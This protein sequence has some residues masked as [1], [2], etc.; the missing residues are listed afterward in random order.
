MQ[1]PY[2]G[3]LDAY[4]YQLATIVYA[5]G[6]THYHRMPAMRG[7]FKPLMR[8]LIQKMLRNEV[9][10]YWYLT[11]Q[12]GIRIDPDLK[13]LR[14]PWPDPIIKENIMYSDH[15]ILMTSL[16]AMPFNDDEYEKPG[17]L[18]FRWEPLFWGMGPEKLKYDNRSLQAAI[19]RQ[20]EEAECAG[21][22]CKPN[23]IFVVCNQFPVC[24]YGDN[25]LHSL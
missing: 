19:L 22:C 24:E 20:M 6:V 16:Y 5:I 14:K 2:Q 7:Y 25:E 9:W 3:F 1:E 17:S 23:V 13:E 21:V 12:S 18:T 15:L 10:S 11:T 4:R 8:R